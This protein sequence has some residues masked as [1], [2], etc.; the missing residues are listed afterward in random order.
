MDTEPRWQAIICPAHLG[1]GR[2]RLKGDRQSLPVFF[3]LDRSPVQQ[4]FQEDV[5]EIAAREF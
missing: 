2:E 4:A 1:I 3:C 5:V